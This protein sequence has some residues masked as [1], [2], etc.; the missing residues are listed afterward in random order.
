LHRGYGI[1]RTGPFGGTHTRRS[2]D[3]EML[4]EGREPVRRLDHRGAFR[5]VT[6]CKEDGS[7]GC[8]TEGIEKD[9][10][11]FIQ[12]TQLGWVVT[13]ALLLAGRFVP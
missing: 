1:G 7:T 3:T 9:R 10:G 11:C 13:L 4:K 8:F 6:W 5:G 2:D 12:A